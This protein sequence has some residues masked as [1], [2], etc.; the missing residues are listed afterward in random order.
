MTDLPVW[1]VALNDSS[2]PMYSIAWAVFREKFNTERV[3]DKFADRRDEILPFLY[4]ILDADELYAERS[5]GGGF[6]PINAVSL[7]GEWQVVEAIPRLLTYLDDNDNDDAIVNDRAAFA[8]QQMPPEAIE[9]LLEHGQRDE[10]RAMDAMFILTHVGK[11][12][13]R[14]FAFI[15]NVFERMTDAFDIVTVAECLAI[16]NLEKADVYLQEQSEKERFR[17]YKSDF[18]KIIEEVKRGDWG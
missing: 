7:L 15:C 13:D 18:K 16:N 6:A 9:P 1:R 4:A 8:L 12:D 5:L 14:C 2:H 3:A 10:A 11:G 17:R